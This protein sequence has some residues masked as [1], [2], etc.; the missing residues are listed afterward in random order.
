[1]KI[2]LAQMSMT[3]KIE[4]NLNKSLN[5][6]DKAKDCDLLFFPEI[7]LSPF[8]PQYQNKNVEKYCLYESSSE[9]QK[10]KEKAKEHSIYISPNVYMSIENKKYDTSLWINRQGNI[11]DKAKMVHIAQAENFYEQDYYT[12]SD[13]GFK[14]FDTEYGK[15]GVVICYDRHL[16]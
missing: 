4:E 8:F 16:P 6:C 5:F 9:I 15:V 3:D 12:P 13:D 7:Q 11:V 1:M 2:A 10:I 14:V